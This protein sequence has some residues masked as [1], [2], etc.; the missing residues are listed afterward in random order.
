MSGLRSSPAAWLS[1]RVD[2]LKPRVHLLQ[3]RPDATLEPGEEVEVRL[4]A[5]DANLRVLELQGEAQELRRDD[6]YVLVQKRMRAPE[7]GALKLPVRA[8]DAAGNETVVEWT[9]NV[10]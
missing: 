10:R 8:V 6:V 2:G 7:T 1:V 4:F 9:W 3:P 5:Y